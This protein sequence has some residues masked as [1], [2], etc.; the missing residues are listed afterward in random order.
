[1]SKIFRN[2]YFTNI[3][4]RLSLRYQILFPL[5]F[6]F[7]SIWT[8]GNISFGVIVNKRLK[9]NLRNDTEEFSLLVQ[10]TFDREKQLLLFKAR[11]I[12]DLELISQ[13]L[14]QKDKAAILKKIIPLKESLNLDFIRAVSKDNTVIIQ[15]KDKKIRQ[16]NFDNSIINQPKIFGVNYSAFIEADQGKSSLLVGLTSVKSLEGIEGKIIVGKLFDNKE[17]NIIRSGIKFH[18]VSFQN[19]KINAS[20]LPAAKSNF[21]KSPPLKSLPINVNIAGENYF[22]KSIEIT[23]FTG[24]K[25]KLVLLNPIAILE[26]NEKQLWLNIFIFSI[27]GA[28]I[29][30]LSITY[31]TKL[32]T[33][34]IAYLTNATKKLASGDFSKEIYISGKDEISTLAQGFNIMSKKIEFLLRK[35]EK[36]K[37]ELE[38]SNQVLEHKV[39]QRTQEIDQKNSYLQKTLEELQFTQTQMIQSE[40]MSALGQMVAGVAHEINNPVG[41]VHGNLTPAREYAQD[42]INIIELYQKHYPQPVEEI[43]N[44]TEAVEL[45]FLKRDFTKLLDSMHVGTQRIREIVLSLRN[46]SRLDEAEFKPVDIHE[47]IDSTLMILCNRLK[48]KP[49]NPEI[50]IIKEYGILTEVECYPSQLNQVFMNILSNAIDALD[51]YNCKRTL[52]EIKTSPSHIKLITEVMIERGFENWVRIRIIDNGPGIA[53]EAHSKL[54]DPFFT[55]KEVGKG[56]GLGLSI[57]YQ[58]IVDKH[59]G[60]LSCHSIPGKMTEFSIEI[61]IQQ[62]EKG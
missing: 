3:Y 10:R 1:M 23:S 17:L 40:K 5:I 54:F 6:I 2:I 7:I 22:A 26:A 15:V 30:S 21:W 55:T 35:Q 13:S 34:R 32:L 31:F 9:D 24:K 16:A 11:W 43:Q 38:V 28:V 59:G 48:A 51:E 50:Q 56:T 58:I 39:L 14:R 25:E 47:G 42:L 49:E 53:Q 41:F 36:I 61:P 62:G 46:F 45:D 27:S 19:E 8:V 57:S 18:L 29:F 37:E 60:K 52:E 33:H 44:E 20:T 4:F 12:A